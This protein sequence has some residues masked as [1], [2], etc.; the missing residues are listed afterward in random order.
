MGY[1]IPD[2]IKY[3]EKIVAN[4]DLKQL[5][6]AVLF[7]MLALIAYKLPLDGAA[8]LILPSIFGIIG[9]AFIFLNMEEKALD[10]V[11]YYVGL[12]KARYNDRNAQRFFEVRAIEN[13]AVY[14]EDGT[15]LA[16]LE[17]QPLNFAL[18]DENRKKALLANYRA[19]L[20]QLTTPVQVFI[21]TDTVSLAGY[22][23]SLKENV[24]GRSGLLVELYADFRIFEEDLLRKKAT[25]NRRYYLVIPSVRPLF[26][27]EPD[28][29]QLGDLVEIMREKLA[30]CD[31]RSVRLGN[32]EL[33]DLYTSYGDKT[34]AQTTAPKPAKGRESKDAYRNDITPSFDIRPDY[35]VVNGEYHGIVKTTGY[36]RKVEDGWLQAFLC[37]NENYDISMH[38]SPSSISGMLVHLHNQIIRQTSDLLLSTAK[39]TPNPALEIKKSDTLQVYNALYKG[40]EKLFGLSLYIDNK[41]AGPGELALLTGKCKSNLNA[42]LMVPKVAFWRMADGI[43][44]TLPL[45]KDRLNSTREVLTGA[46]AA[47]FPFIAAANSE[48]KGILFAH[49][50]QTL[51][52]IF[53]DPENQSNKHFFIIGISGSGKSY[54]AKYFVIQQLLKRETGLYIL[55]PNGEYSGLCKSLGGRVIEISKDSKYILNL[56]DMNGEDF[57]GKMLQLVS[58]F[59][60]IM[61]GLNESQKAVISDALTATYAR[62][63]ITSR[64]ETWFRVP[65][66]FS[67]LKTAIEHMM[68][69]LNSMSPQ[70]KSLDAIYRR[71][72]MYCEDGV[73]GF[74]DQDTQVKADGRVLC[75]DLSRLPA[76]IKPLLIFMVLGFI[77]RKISLDKEA[78]AV[79]IDEGWVLLRSKEAEQYLLE[80]VKSSRKFNASIGFITQEVEDL[81]Q[82]STGKSILNTA[83]VKILMRQSPSSIRLVSGNL[84]LNEFEEQYIMTA[85][86]G[87]GLVITE[88]NSYCFFIRASPKIHQLI[89]TNPDEKEAVIVSDEGEKIVLDFRKGMY[90]RSE[91]TESAV[92]E[93][94]AHGYN[95]Y[96]TRITSEKSYIEYLIKVRQNEGEEHAFLCWFTADLLAKKRLKPKVEAAPGPDIQV[97][98]KGKKIC[99]EIETGKRLKYGK[100]T[101]MAARL[102]ERKRQYAAVYVV[103]PNERVGRSYHG[104]CENILTKAELEGFIRTLV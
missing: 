1:D 73:F 28:V 29:K 12:R 96:E 33:E 44:S 82:S 18:L 74:L 6:Y 47:T 31:L 65:P 26:G 39:G 41:A 36:P 45:A 70:A 10:V 48:Q 42:Q 98:I 8:K 21:R 51:N 76:A 86:K 62:K 66:R 16:I 37:R 81:L 35:A 88:D 59:D 104:L 40:E 38:I 55:D 84:R 101:E 30:G 23:D 94:V 75:F 58:A 102:S 17:V 46:L 32:K 4:L 77:Q 87:Q 27:K 25:R 54:T 5:G 43:R 100:K 71:V 61:G 11:S 83:S 90:L 7:G 80:F 69:E 79:L 91:L 92:G 64:P 15:V 34:D 24:A 89:T 3:K 103:V 19:F 63:G 67:D 56:F 49:E 14:L 50:I 22:F 20:N 52:P 57:G 78:K 13:D 97:S 72:K 60:I 93:L 85:R 95:I 9:V 53:L 2:E 99:F 68:K